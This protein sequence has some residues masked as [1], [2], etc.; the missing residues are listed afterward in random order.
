MLGDSQ[1]QA[2]ACDFERMPERRLQLHLTERLG[3]PVRRLS[4]AASGYGQDQKLLA[5]GEYFQ[6]YRADL[7]LLRL[8]PENDVWN[9]K[10]PTHFPTDG[11][12]KPTFRL[13][14]DELK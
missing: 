12:S 10:F 3:R 11:W 13:A 1:V 7:V 8:T 5:L 2:L 4:L 14:D 9:K 6:Q